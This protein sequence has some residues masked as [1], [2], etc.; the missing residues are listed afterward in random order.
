MTIVC[1]CVCISL[2]QG[3]IKIYIH[4]QLSESYLN[5]NSEI[6]GH[7]RGSW[8]SSWAGGGKR[9]SRRIP[10]RP[11]TAQGCFCTCSGVLPRSETCA[12]PGGHGPL[13]REV[14][15][16]AHTDFPSLCLLHSSTRP[17]PQLSRCSV[18]GRLGSW[19]CPW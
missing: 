17:C 6:P 15:V 13:C 2:L 4:T 12:P 7:R 3:K 8:C 10:R 19:R 11:P 16:W 9:I 5:H 1:V 14:F 18:T